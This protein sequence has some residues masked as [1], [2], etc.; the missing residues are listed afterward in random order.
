MQQ[1]NSIYTKQ[2]PKLRALFEQAGTLNKVVCVALDFA[3]AKHLVLFCN[4]QGDILKKPFP[5]HNS[6]AG[7][8]SLL[9]ELQR[10]CHHRAIPPK[11]VFFGGEDRPSYAENF[12]TQLTARGHLF[13]RVNAWEAKHQRDNHQ[14]STDALDLLGI[15]KCLLQHK[16]QTDPVEDVLYPNLREATRAR[17]Y[18][19][20]QQTALKNH[21]HGYSERL[22]PGFLVPKHSGIPP[23]S[24]AS[25]WLMSQRFSPQQIA[26]RKPARLQA[27]LQRCG[28]EQPQVAAQKLQQWAA[29][30]LPP[31]TGRCPSWQC[32]LTQHLRVYEALE[33]AIAA[34][35]REVA[36]YLAQTPGAFLT[37]FRGIGVVLAAGLTGELGQVASWRGVRHLCSYCGVVPRI[38][39]TGGPDRPAH[40]GPVQRRC[41]RRAK[42]WLVQCA[43]KL[44]EM[45]PQELQTQY[46]QLAQQ[47]QHADFVM[48]KRFLRLAKDLVRR[49]TVYR[50]KALLGPQTP[51]TDLVSYYAQLWPK[52]VSKWQGLC[53][54]NHVFAPEHPLGQWRIMAQDLYQLCLP[55]PKTTRG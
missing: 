54:L 18:L 25:L 12:I 22:F 9:E 6:P 20:R 39:Q 37:S 10:T 21:I 40:A 11:Q 29:Q 14:A 34:S 47:G 31:A 48:S 8:D 36:Y 50:P 13:L 7:L 5:I 53:P 51:T 52:L 33:Q 32:S 24:K 45:G 3:K 2:N 26:L 41:N 4:G 28:L 30:V 46:Q 27:G 1:V 19:V 38:E 55:L 17:S 35:E 15:A 44:G 42:N 49:Q 16:G 23:F 43:R